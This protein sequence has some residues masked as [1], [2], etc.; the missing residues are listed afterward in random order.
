M[1]CI[2]NATN[3]SGEHDEIEL[4]EEMIEAGVE[5]FWAWVWNMARRKPP[6]L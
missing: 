1:R 6:P 4:T 5:A 2:A 3:E